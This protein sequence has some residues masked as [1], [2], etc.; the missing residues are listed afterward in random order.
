MK[1]ID[2]TNEGELKTGDVELSQA[3]ITYTQEPDNC[4]A[5]EDYQR[6][7]I[8]IEDAGGGKFIVINTD[9]WAID[10]IDYFITILHDFKRRIGVKGL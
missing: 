7:K 6:L 10:S 9:R 1:I 8:H 2:E 3:T 4:S 5:S